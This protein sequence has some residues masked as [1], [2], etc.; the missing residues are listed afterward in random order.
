[1]LIRKFRAINEHVHHDQNHLLPKSQI[2]SA[3]DRD[4]KVA[5][6]E[7]TDNAIR[8]VEVIEIKTDMKSRGKQMIENDEVT[9]NRK[10]PPRVQL[11][12]EGMRDLTGKLWRKILSSRRHWIT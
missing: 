1:M 5:A 6:A 12:V 2:E 10:I 11:Q 9:R 7:I 4:P 8:T 3:P